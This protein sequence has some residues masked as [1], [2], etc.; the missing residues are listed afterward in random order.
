MINWIK[1]L[2]SKIFKNHKKRKNEEDDHT[3]Y[4]LY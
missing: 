2:L 4:P 3:N 1:D